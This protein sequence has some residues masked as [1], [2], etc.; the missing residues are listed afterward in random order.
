MNSFMA[1]VCSASAGETPPFGT[2]AL[3]GLV[4]FLLVFLVL[5]VLIGIVYLVRLAFVLFTGKGKKKTKEKTAE[6]IE[7]KQIVS[8]DSDE[9]IAAV[10]A[11]VIATYTENGT[12]K[13]AP[14]K[15][16]KIYKIK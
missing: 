10:I 15:V 9:E 2:M 5:A 12:G 4:G 7:S 6:P 3:Y 14:F 11:A 8:V 1:F 16:K 13:T